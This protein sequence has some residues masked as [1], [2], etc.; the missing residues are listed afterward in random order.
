VVYEAWL[1]DDAMAEWMC[2]HPARP[3][4]IELDARIGGRYL[5]DIDDEGFELSVT[6]EYLVLDPPHRLSFTWYC[7]TWKPGDPDS[8]VTVD[9]QPHGDEET[10]MTIRHERL[11]VDLV[12]GH[13]R[14]WTLIAGQLGACMDPA[15]IAGSA[16]D[17]GHPGPAG[18]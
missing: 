10:L 4:R 9:L 6:G 1:D 2:P 17:S 18:P 13:Q 8:I 7:S 16:S 3:V 5:I 11:P 12:D 14:G 15:S